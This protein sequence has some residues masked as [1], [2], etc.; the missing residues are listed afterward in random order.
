MGGLEKFLCIHADVPERGKEVVSREK[1]RGEGG[2]SHY[3][4]YTL[5]HTHTNTK[6][7][8]GSH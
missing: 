1:K 3:S 8:D 6:D 2:L 5:V 7:T 4:T